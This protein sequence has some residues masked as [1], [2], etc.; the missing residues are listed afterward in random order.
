MEVTT[1]INR[2]LMKRT[3]QHISEQLR[4]NALPRIAT[5]V[6]IALNPTSAI[7]RVELEVVRVLDH[8]HI[9][10]RRAYTSKYSKTQDNK[11]NEEV[12]HSLVR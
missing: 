9:P 8:N 11:E 1:R 7:A 4:N 2:G 12:E 3:T 10:S 6:A 5:L